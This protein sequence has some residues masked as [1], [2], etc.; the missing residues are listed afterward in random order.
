MN[1]GIYELIFLSLD[2][3]IN[4]MEFITV[5]YFCKKKH[6]VCRIKYF[7]ENI[8]TQV[9]LLAFFTIHAG[10]CEG[11]FTEV[12]VDPVGVVPVPHANYSLSLPAPGT[13]Q[14]HVPPTAD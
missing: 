14:V 8:P 11:L 9:H 5:F 10:H 3:F 2:I 6:E 4:F 13:D 1:T 12:S 7:T